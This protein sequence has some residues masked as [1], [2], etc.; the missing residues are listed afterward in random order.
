MGNVVHMDS[1][2]PKIFGTCRGQHGQLISKLC[3]QKIRVPVIFVCL[4]DL[5][6]ILISVNFAGKTLVFNIRH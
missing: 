2:Y 3:S 4:R 1:N 5:W 6:I